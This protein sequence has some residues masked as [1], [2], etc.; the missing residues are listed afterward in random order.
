M[1]S[2]CSTPTDANPPPV[3][4]VTA[5]WLGTHHMKAT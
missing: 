5:H 1:A 2:H 4:A 3:F